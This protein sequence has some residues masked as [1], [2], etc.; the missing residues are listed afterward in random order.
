MAKAFL[1][2]GCGKRH[3]SLLHP[4]PPTLKGADR[5]ARC[6]TQ[7]SLP[8]GDLRNVPSGAER[9]RVSLQIVPV[10]VRGGEDGPD[11]NTYAFLDNGSGTTLWLSSL[12]VSKKPLH[13]SLFSINAENIPKSG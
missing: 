8:E 1:F 10:R 3:H 9:S 6:T 13:F 4:P 7:E 11:I 12:G 2:S 5:P